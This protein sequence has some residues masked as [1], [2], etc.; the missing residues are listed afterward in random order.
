MIRVIVLVVAT[1][2]ASKHGDVCEKATDS[3]LG[4]PRKVRDCGPGLHCCYPCG[5][6]GC[7]SVCH[8]A[9]ECAYDIK[10]N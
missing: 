9:A 8:T 2:R 5:I 6:V 3:P 7:D 10:R 4:L 1:C